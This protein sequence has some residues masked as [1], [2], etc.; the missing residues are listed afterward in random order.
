MQAHALTWVPADQVVSAD[1]VVV[2]PV[3]LLRAVVRADQVETSKRTS[4]PEKDGR[5]EIIKREV[6]L[7]I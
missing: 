2:V 7:K 1:R 5:L 3:D 6:D 4:I